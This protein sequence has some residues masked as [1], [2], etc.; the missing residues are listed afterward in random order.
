MR[1]FEVAKRT[2]SLKHYVWSSLPYI[3]KVRRHRPASNTVELT[4]F[5]SQKANFNPEYKVDHADAKGKVAEWMSV[6]PSLVG[7]DGLTWSIITS[8]PYMEMLNGVCT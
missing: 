2:K 8:A 3:L 5:H 6:Q 4:D 1:I 7:D